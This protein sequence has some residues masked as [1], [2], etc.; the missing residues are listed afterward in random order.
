MHRVLGH[1]V[2]WAIIGNN[3]VTAAEPPRVQRTEIEILA[4]D[5]I[6]SVLDA[7]RGRPLYPIVLTGLATGMRRGEMAALRWADIDLTAA[8]SASSGH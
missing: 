6:K 3:P 4:P 5:Q 2:K 1:A 7:L 8:K